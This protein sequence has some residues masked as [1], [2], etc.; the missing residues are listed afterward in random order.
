VAAALA[1]A[2]RALDRERATRHAERLIGWGEG[3]TPAGDDFLVGL[4]AGLDALAS[5]DPRRRSFLEAVAATLVRDASR[6]TP[7]AS[8]PSPCRRHHTEPLIVCATP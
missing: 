2:C 1:D 4:I 7:I 6:T 3:L 8:Q 5:G